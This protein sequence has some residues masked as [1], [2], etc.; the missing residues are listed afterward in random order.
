MESILDSIKQMLGLNSDYYAFD[1][2]LIIYINMVLNTLTQI[3]VGPEEGFTIH[4]ASTNWDEFIG[5]D[6]CLEM[7]KS[8]I[9]LRVKKLFDSSSST[10]ALLTAMDNQIKELE[11]RISVQVDPGK[12]EV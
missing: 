3:G 11:W 6:K 5:E 4:D 10:S 12:K 9:H 2:E 1:E 7:V 8:Y